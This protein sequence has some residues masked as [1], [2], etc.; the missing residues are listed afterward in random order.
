MKK[1]ILYVLILSMALL[2]IGCAKQKETTG[3]VSSGDV[4]T[5]L[6]KDVQSLDDLNGDLDT[7]ELDEVESDTEIGDL[8]D[9]I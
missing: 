8:L 9:N 3:V 2:V 4:S 5:N 1:I 6:E 7:N